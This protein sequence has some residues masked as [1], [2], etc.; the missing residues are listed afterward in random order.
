MYGHLATTNRAAW[1]GRC[2]TESEAVAAVARINPDVAGYEC[3]VHWFFVY[4]PS[5]ILC[6]SKEDERFAGTLAAFLEVNLP[7]KVSCSEA[8]VAPGVDLMQ[9]AER[10]LSGDIAL[11]LLSPSSVPAVWNRAVW[12]PLLLEKPKELATRVGFVLVAECRF[13]ALLRRENFF[14]ASADA[15]GAVRAIKRW[16][17]QPGRGTGPAPKVDDEIEEMRRA[18]ADRPGTVGGVDAG[19]AMRFAERCAEDFEVVYRFDCRGRS[20]AGIVGDVGSAIGLPM[21]GSI[22]QN[23][24]TLREW[25]RNHRALFVLACAEDVDNDFEPDGG[26]ASVIFTAPFEGVLADCTR[27]R[28]G[29][30]V[31]RLQEQ[32]A[33]EARLA[34][35]WAAV[36]LLEAQGRFVEMLEVLEAMR[37]AARLGGDAQARLQIERQLYW[38]RH[39]LDGGDGEAAAPPAG[40]SQGFQLS[41]PG[42]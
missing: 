23:V 12:E 2:R 8:V 7:A 33:T 37:E 28:T 38:T 32:G 34:S 30:A 31:R 3:G 26:R 13:P 16:V 17:L 6:S 42:I 10:A 11:V 5:L 9:A 41:L 24:V 39:D 40:D 20:R 29:D 27:S 19:L 21:S 15:L 4:Q 36:K 35:G 25:R 18:V 14:D 22:E 1:H